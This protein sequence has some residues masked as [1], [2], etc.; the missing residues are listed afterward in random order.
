MSGHGSVTLVAAAIE[1]AGLPG[2]ERRGLV[3][4][5]EIG[6]ALNERA[7]AWYQGGGFKPLP[8]GPADRL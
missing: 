7:A 5:E 6:A 8:G 4:F 3:G 2:S 1:V